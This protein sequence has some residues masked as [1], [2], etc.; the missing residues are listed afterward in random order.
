MEEEDK[1]IEE[2]SKID[3]EEG[4]TFWFTP[5]PKALPDRLISSRSIGVETDDLL[6]VHQPESN[7]VPCIHSPCPNVTSSHGKETYHQSLPGTNST[8]AEN[9]PNQKIKTHLIIAERSQMHLSRAQDIFDESGDKAPENKPNS[10]VPPVASNNIDLGISQAS[11]PSNHLEGS[12]K[13]GTSSAIHINRPSSPKLTKKQQRLRKKLEKA[14]AKATSTLPDGQSISIPGGAAQTA[15]DPIP[16]K[17]ETV[18]SPTP[19]PAT[20]NHENSTEKRDP[21]LG[22]RAGFRTE[23]VCG[24]RVLL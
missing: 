11:M 17:S 8:H 21:S 6:L 10:E 13:A 3:Q 7:A 12:N 24:I 5:P 19:T 9:S 23:S 1:K 4:R 20:S 15:A 18:P 16:T 14:A 2:A 22:L